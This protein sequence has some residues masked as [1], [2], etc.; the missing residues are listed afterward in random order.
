MQEIYNDERIGGTMPDFR[1]KK[2]K[3]EL[4]CHSLEQ[5]STRQTDRIFLSVSM[6]PFPSL[7]HTQAM[8]TPGRA[9][10]IIGTSSLCLC[11]CV[12]VCM[13]GGKRG[14]DRE[15]DE[16]GTEKDESSK[17]QVNT[18]HTQWK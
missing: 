3:L 17:N 9:E 14:S 2:V 7:P 13:C 15:R 5:Q 12:C 8:Q 16:M 1:F 4:T 6:S 18:H 11:V 10:R